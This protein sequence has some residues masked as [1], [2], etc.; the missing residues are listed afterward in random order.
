MASFFDQQLVVT[1]LSKLDLE[2]TFTRFR[3]GINEKYK[4]KFTIRDNI[5]EDV[6]FSE[7]RP[8]HFSPVNVGTFKGDEFKPDIR[9][10]KIYNRTGDYSSVKDESKLNHINISKRY[11][12]GDDYHDSEISGIQIEKGI[13]PFVNKYLTPHVDYSGKFLKYDEGDHFDTFHYDTLKKSYERGTL[14]IF[15]PNKYN[16]FTGGHLIFKNDGEEKI[17]DPSQFTDWTA[18]AFGKILHKCTPITSGTRYVLK[19][20]IKAYIPGI[21]NDDTYFKK[22]QI[23]DLLATYDNTKVK[24]NI[25]EQV[26]KLKQE[27]KELITEKQKLEK[28]FYDEMLEN[29]LSGNTTYDNDKHD[30]YEESRNSNSYYLTKNF[31]DTLTGKTY[32]NYELETIN[33]QI[34]TK[35][36]EYQFLTYKLNFIDVDEL[37]INASEI[38]TSVKQSSYPV[39]YYTGTYYKDINEYKMD[40]LK[41][42]NELIDAGLQVFPMNTEVS[43]TLL[44][45]EISRGYGETKYGHKMEKYTWIKEGEFNTG[46]ISSKYSE[47]NDESGYDK[48]TIYNISCF[49]IYN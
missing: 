11:Y 34:D 46:M 4:T 25:E 19:Y 31:N 40:H 9:S 13:L 12:W 8:E 39:V 47:Y 14:L 42:I 48:L 1:K 27:I 21:I 23:N 38:I 32:E 3:S 35:L 20:T 24:Q 16:V 6:F 17:V 43:S 28:E 33:T 45:E 18:V 5:K 49:L 2:A 15:P 30:K 41:L 10:G 37:R 44:H 29:I 36:L 7:L 26:L 22:D